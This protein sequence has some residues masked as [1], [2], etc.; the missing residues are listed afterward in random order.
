MGLTTAQALARHYREEQT[1]WKAM[2]ALPT[3]GPQGLDTVEGMG[4]TVVT[5]LQAFVADERN[6]LPVH[7]LREAVDV[8]P[9]GGGAVSGEGSSGNERE[10]VES[11]ATGKSILF[12]GTLTGMSR[13]K[14][15]ARARELSPCQSRPSVGR[16]MSW[17]WEPGRGARRRK[18]GNWA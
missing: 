9:E 12:T 6:R 1:W 13:S 7:S 4:P 5:A 11:P 15:E 18:R 3:A 16:W 2:E 10:V 17:R 14:A 8:Q